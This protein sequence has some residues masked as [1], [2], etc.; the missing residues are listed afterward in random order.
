MM[1]FIPIMSGQG[2]RM[3]KKQS[4]NLDVSLEYHG[5]GVKGGR[6]DG[7]LVAQEILGFCDFALW[8]DT[9]PTG[10]TFRYTPK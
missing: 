1:I 6:M 7:R 8:P 10:E 5:P 2:V 9:L 3:A 4:D